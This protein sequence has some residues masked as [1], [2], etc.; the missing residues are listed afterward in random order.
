MLKN[1]ELYSFQNLLLEQKNS[2]V[3][4]LKSQLAYEIMIVRH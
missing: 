3:Y 1:L 2:K 4:L